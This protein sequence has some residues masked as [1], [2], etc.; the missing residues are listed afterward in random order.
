MWQYVRVKLTKDGTKQHLTVHRFNSFVS[1]G[2]NSSF[3]MHKKFIGDGLEFYV[4]TTN[5]DGWFTPD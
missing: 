1:G 5:I 4:H 2:Q 3:T